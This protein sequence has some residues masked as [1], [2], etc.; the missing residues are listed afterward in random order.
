MLGDWLFLSVRAVAFTL[1]SSRWAG[2]KKQKEVDR[3]T[4]LIVRENMTTQRNGHEVELKS[5]SG[6]KP[7]APHYSVASVASR[8]VNVPRDD[9]PLFSET[10]RRR[11]IWC[12][13]SFSVEVER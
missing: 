3:C 5:F 2:E 4:G 12:T 6:F 1:G 7:R 13:R 10:R 9:G 8:T 11:G